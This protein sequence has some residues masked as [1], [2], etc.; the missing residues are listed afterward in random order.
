MPNP[1]RLVI[2]ID[3]GITGALALVQAS[4]SV[5]RLMDVK[6]VPTASAKVNG[7][8]KSHVILPGLV[9]ILRDWTDLPFATSVEVFLEEVH[10]M[11]GQGVTSMFRFGHVAGA[12]EG[13]CAGMGLAV[14]TIRPREW[15]TIARVRK[16][17][18]AGRL[19]ASQLFPA[20]SSLFTRKKDHNRADAAL[21][22]YAGA[23]MRQGQFE[24]ESPRTVNQS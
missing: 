4:G 9:D 20:M 7:S 15:Q 19:R 14:T 3:P 11:P 2:G 10:A 8:N 16:D 24:Q 23:T 13:V 1:S 12:I 17:P 21:I 6:D 18:D 22:A 5:L